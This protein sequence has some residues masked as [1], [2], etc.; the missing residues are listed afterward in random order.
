MW[1]LKMKL[2][3]ACGSQHAKESLI[4]PVVTISRQLRFFNHLFFS[5]LL[6][7]S[8]ADTHFTTKL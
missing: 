2:K 1:Y 6:V 5:L 4:P 8:N 7:L 3:D